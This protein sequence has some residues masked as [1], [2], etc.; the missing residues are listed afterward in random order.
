MNDLSYQLDLSD[1]F[2][3]SGHG[4]DEDDDEEAEDTEVE[5]SF[6]KEEIHFRLC[7]QC[8]VVVCQVGSFDLN[9]TSQ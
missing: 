5:N 6:C 8:S 7:T 2:S 3:D 9:L 1:S 4:S